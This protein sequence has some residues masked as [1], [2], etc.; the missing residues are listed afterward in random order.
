M[1]SK[2]RREPDSCTVAVEVE[3]HH[4]TIQFE[5]DNQ[6][7]NIY[8]HPDNFVL[9]SGTRSWSKRRGEVYTFHE[10]QYKARESIKMLCHKLKELDRAAWNDLSVDEVMAS[11]YENI[12][13]STPMWTKI[14]RWFNGA[15]TRLMEAV[16]AKLAIG[17]HTAEAMGSK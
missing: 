16:G 8:V 14:K 4:I 2:S 10:N 6:V 9:T 12:G 7:R 5:A 11:I 3:D 1:F 15:V 13:M 17:Y